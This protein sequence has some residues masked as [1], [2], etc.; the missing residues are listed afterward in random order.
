MYVNCNWN[1]HISILTAMKLIVKV[2]AFPLAHVALVKIP[3]VNAL[4][5]G[6][7]LVVFKNFVFQSKIPSVA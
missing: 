3:L 2:I 5:L 4:A 1:V 7:Q 6:N